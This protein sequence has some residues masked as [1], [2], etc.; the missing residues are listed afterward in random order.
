[1]DST[2]SAADPEPEAPAP[3][4]VAASTPIRVGRVLH[5]FPR[6]RAASLAI[7]SGELRVGDLL[8]FRGHTT[9]FCQRL[10]CLELEGR[11][12]QRAGAGQTVGVAVAQRVR[13]RDAVF[14]LASAARSEP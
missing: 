1:M 3:R 2:G 10:E 6:A 9:D 4:E 14:R 13:E 11:P 12:A 7:E 8:H 5:F